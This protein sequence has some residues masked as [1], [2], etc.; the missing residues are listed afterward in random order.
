M[1]IPRTMRAA[2]YRGVDDVRVES[3]A[4]PAISKGEVLVKVHTLRDLRDRP[5]EDPF[6]FA[7]GSARVWA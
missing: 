3:V 6:R 7:F 4:V 2:V 1:S 5:E